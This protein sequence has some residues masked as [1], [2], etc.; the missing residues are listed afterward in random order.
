MYNRNMIPMLQPTHKDARKFVAFSCPHAPLHDKHALGVIRD[1]IAEYQP[2]YIIC[3]G[4]LHEADSASKWPSEYDFTLEDEYRS[5]SNEVLKPLRESAGDDVKCFLLPG[6]HDANIEEIG[7]IDAGLR[8]LCDWK[9]PQYDSDG[10][11]INEEL[12][13]HWQIPRRYDYSKH[14]TF[15]L[16]KVTFAHGW[17]AGGGSDKFECVYLA[18]PNGLYV[19]GHTHRP[20]GGEPKQVMMS[21]TMPLPYYFLNAGCT[22]DLNPDYMARKRKVMWGQG[23]VYGWS[24]IN[25]SGAMRKGKTWDA[26]CEII[27]MH[28]DA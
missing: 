24:Q 13:E 1:R 6:N 4:D 22:R 8:P 26:Y 14:N 11:W 9:K 21:Q 19:R 27:R 5:A 7:R 23:V 12:C 16:G 20:T 17:E 2:D 15:K 28:G 3:L 25:S 18:D 10:V